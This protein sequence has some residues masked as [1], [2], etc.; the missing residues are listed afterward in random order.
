MGQAPLR[1]LSQMDMD[2]Q[3]GSPNYSYLEPLLAIDPELKG[4]P[5]A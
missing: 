3:K 4:M 2:T 5:R 1:L